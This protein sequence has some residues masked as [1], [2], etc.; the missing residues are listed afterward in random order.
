MSEQTQVAV[1]PKNGLA[2]W[3]SRDEVKEI[4][5][6]LKKFVPGTKKMNDQ[7]VMAYA[8][9]VHMTGLNPCRNELYGWDSNGDGTGSLV[10]KLYYGILV[11]WAQSREPF[12]AQFMTELD[13]ES[14][15]VTS[16]C[17]LLRQSNR[18]LLGQLLGNKVDYREAL[19][20]ATTTGL[21]IVTAREQ[22][23]RKPPHS[24]D[25]R[26]VAEKRALEDSIKRTY[27]TPSTQELARQT[28]IV[29]GVKTISSDWEEVTPEMLP[30]TR[31]ATAKYSATVRQ[32][33]AE[34][35][36]EPPRSAA[37]DIDLLFGAAMED[38]S[39][40]QAEPEPEPPAGE[41]PKAPPNG[42][43]SEPEASP[44]GAPP[45]PARDVDAIKT[46]GDCWTACQEDF[47]LDRTQALAELGV[48]KQEHLGAR[49]PRDLYLEIAAVRT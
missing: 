36:T 38:T 49:E 16:R 27:G 30:A 15:D 47:G 1:Q 43:E 46:F 11:N 29:D 18:L 6:R 48:T 33:Q 39:P 9:L 19:A 5:A 44:N 26:W 7:E 32:L 23:T 28:W 4:A 10:T 12:T 8:Q 35:E 40:T 20:L 31:E 3:G 14:Q 17:Q 13:P 22:R 2:P 42:L 25:W 37:E 41:A 21:G 45:T 24:K 34:R